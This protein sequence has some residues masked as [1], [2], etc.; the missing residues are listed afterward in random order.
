MKNWRSFSRKLWQSQLF[1]GSAILFVGSMVA[2]FGNYLYHL[3]TGRMLG[4]VNYGLLASLISLTY[5]FAI[6]MSALSLVVTKYISALKGRG[7]LGAAAYFYS[8]LNKKL[9]GFILVAFFLMIAASSRLASFI[10]IESSSLIWLVFVYSL[11]GVYLTVN[12]ATLQGLLRFNL[13]AAL[14]LIQV[15]LKLGLAVFLIFLG[16]EVLGAVLSFL[17][18]VIGA[19]LLAAFFVLRLLPK[20]KKAKKIDVRELIKYAVPVLFSTM[21]FTSLYTTDIVL[22]RHFLPAQEAG[23]YAALALL[24]K[25]IF[26]ASGP[27]IMVMFPMV[28]ERHANG[29]GYSNLFKLS[30]GLVFLICLGISGIYFLFP[31][32]M[33]RMLYGSQYLPAAPYLFLFAI[34]LSFY[35][36]AFLLVNFHLSVKKIKVVLLPLAAAVSQIILIFFFHQSLLQVITVSMVLLG[37][38]FLALLLN[39]FLKYDRIQK[40]LTFRYRPC[41]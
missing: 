10:H 28:S 35:S 38:L 32:L 36:L 1:A 27:I 14:S 16:W 9:I 17:I 13:M 30:F 23:F 37:L 39:S 41:L 20:K 24:G 21:A 8:W 4:P 34:F 22:V 7:E 15:F 19:C 6:P 2:N 18:G 25:I 11:V 5:W 40:T 12:S 29:R 3:L 26:F 33:V 31:K